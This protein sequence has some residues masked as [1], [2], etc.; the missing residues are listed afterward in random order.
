MDIFHEGKTHLIKYVTILLLVMG[1]LYTM[2]ANADEPIY[3]SKDYEEYD[4]SIDPEDDM[5]IKW[6]MHGVHGK[7][8]FWRAQCIT[9]YMPITD[10]TTMARNA[11][12]TAMAG[13]PS[14]DIN[15]KICSMVLAYLTQYGLD[16]MEKYKVVNNY[17]NRARYHFEMYDFYEYIMEN[18]GPKSYRVEH[19]HVDEDGNRVEE[20]TN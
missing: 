6:M 15:S 2:K 7:E 17:L 1:V 16:A 3:Y 4:D 10:D 12:V 18:E 20:E 14:Y 11:F 9:W 13:L 19:W 8:L 5:W